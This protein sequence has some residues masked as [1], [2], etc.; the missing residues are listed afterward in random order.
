VIK[1][2]GWKDRLFEMDSLPNDEIDE[3]LIKSSEAKKNDVGIINP[4][5]GAG[6]LIREDQTIEAFADYGLGFRIDPVTQSFSIFAPTIKFFCNKKEE[7]NW[8]EHFTY[9]RDEYKDVI[10]ILEGEE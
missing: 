5:N 1:M 2:E 10:D 3:M 9:L 8:N 7:F 4:N 6:M